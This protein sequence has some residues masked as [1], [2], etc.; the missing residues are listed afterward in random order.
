MIGLTAPVVWRSISADFFFMSRIRIMPDDLAS[1]VAAG[2]VVERPASVVKEL[3]ENSLDAGA[4]SVDVQIDRAGR[5]LIRVTDDGGGMAR[6]DAL[7]AL[8]RHATSKIGSKEDLMAI[9]SLGF[10]GEA[11][12][13]IASVSKFRM[14]TRE[15]GSLAAT[16][17]L[18]NGGRLQ[19][20]RDGGGAPGTMIEVR[21]LFYNLP[22]RRKFLRTEAT[23]WGHVEQQV[24]VLALAHPDVRFR[25]WRDGRTVLDLPPGGT[26]AERICG[27]IGGDLAGR[28]LE[29]P[30]TEV[31]GLGL[32]GWVGPPGLG[33]STRDLA[34]TFLN[35]RA[36]ESPVLSYGLREG[37]H[38]GLMKGQHPVAFLFLEMDPAEVDVNV[39]PAKRE[40]R[41]HH[42]QQV[43]RAVAETVGRVLAL[44]RDRPSFGGVTDAYRWQQAAPA[45]DADGPGD[46]GAV[47][48]AELPAGDAGAAPGTGPGA[49]PAP[50]PELIPAA[51]QRALRHDWATWQP[52]AAGGVPGGGDGGGSPVGVDLD[53]VGA[54]AGG[55]PEL[56]ARGAAASR[57]AG[58]DQAAPAS[59]PA[60]LSAAAPATAAPG[61]AEFRILGILNKLYVLL[62]SSDGLVLMDQH[63]AHE[64]VLFEQ[65]RRQ[66]ESGGVASQ[67]LLVPVTLETTPRDAEL[68][69]RHLEVLQRL[70]IGLEPF[71]PNVFKVESLPAFVRSDEPTALL[72]AML[73]ELRKESSRMSALRLGEDVVA[74][75]VCRQAV[76]ANDRLKEPEVERLLADLLACELP[77]CCPHGRPTLVLI[78][79]NELERR[80]GRR[81]P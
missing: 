76:K 39:H 80:F 25:L 62:E 75:T 51:E 11:L 33:R 52:P 42:G 12:P 17:I 61:A 10:R 58:S 57:P 69:R 67:R 2:E 38:T 29:V 23:E 3:V 79:N 49:V 19:E 41:F 32:H 37:Y 66:M 71:G 70:G 36:V 65:L 63:A 74:T 54:V 50:Q 78:P 28:L 27:L 22:A 13:S 81:A 9:R 4:R 40:V 60:G 43:R 55:A 1:Q 72:D 56:A 26:L 64:R 21:S 35:R 18:V 47:A 44:R 15:P 8:E 53:E 68:L 46:G 6:D 16:E 31:S 34:L 5:A 14:V 30:R 77:Y 7:L 48:G 73:E 45:D 59:T 24:R 20:V